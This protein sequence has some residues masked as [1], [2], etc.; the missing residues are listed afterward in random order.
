MIFDLQIK[1]LINF[2]WRCHLYVATSSTH[3]FDV[4]LRDDHT[5]E[6]F[7]CHSIIHGVFCGFYSWFYSY[8]CGKDRFDNCQHNTVLNFSLAYYI[9]KETSH[10]IM[11]NFFMHNK[12]LRFCTTTSVNLAKVWLVSVYT[13]LFQKTVL[14][15][16]LVLHLH[17]HL[18]LAP[19]L[20]TVSMLVV[21]IVICFSAY[22]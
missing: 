12:V 3:K 8:F 21:L 19:V 9:F 10:S 22:V 7:W 16:V 1:S 14:H 6:R 5:Y 4:L 17:L 11:L 18:V 2:S 13:N 20:F 15:L